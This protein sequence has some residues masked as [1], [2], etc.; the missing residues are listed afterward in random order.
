MD[1]LLPYE[2]FYVNSQGVQLD[3]SCAPYIMTDSGLFDFRWS[4]TTA[5]RPLGEGCR[6]LAG[7][8]PCEEKELKV[9]VLAD[10]ESELSERLAAMNSVFDAD[11]VRMTAGRL[12]I[13]GQYLCC[14]CVR[15][16]K[17]LSCDFTNTATVT[18]S[19]FPET[20]V[21]CTEKRY[22]FLPGGS[23]DD[24]G[25]KYDFAYPYRYGAGRRSLT[26]NN[27]HVAGA[28]MRIYF[29]GPAEQPQIF[30]GTACIGLD[31]TLARG[32]YAVIDQLS[33]EIY[34]VNADGNRINC[35]DNRIKNGRTFEHAAPGC[36][37][38]QLV[39]D[40]GVDII[41]IE[42]RSEPRWALS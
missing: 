11:V 36:S 32:E 12:Y 39:G 38:V 23:E 25:H 22:S 40:F 30:V 34:R 42:Q 15:S 33:R 27:E 29:F 18:L 31:L 41:L 10:S 2:A 16:E 17:A 37:T 21:W 7:K 28:P 35:F 9:V 4:L 13:N 24:G 19:V 1:R 8:R 5:G 20:P 26:V 6:M 14:W 3:L